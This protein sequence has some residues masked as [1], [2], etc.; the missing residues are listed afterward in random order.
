[1]ADYRVDEPILDERF[2]ALG[3]FH[4]AI[5]RLLARAAA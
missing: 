5:M 2:E 1:L 4:R 3:D